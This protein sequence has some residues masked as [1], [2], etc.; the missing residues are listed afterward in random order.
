MVENSQRC[1]DTGSLASFDQARAW[2][3]TCITEHEHCRS[4]NSTFC[5]TRLLRLDEGAESL[6]L[7]VGSDISPG[8]QYATLS[9]CW[10]GTVPGQLTMKNIK[11]LQSSVPQ[12]FLGKTFRDAAKIA[13]ELGLRFIWIDS[14]CIIQDSPEDWQRESVKISL[15]YGNSTCNIA[16]T[17]ASNSS[18]GCFRAHDRSTLKPVKFTFG[19]DGRRGTEDSLSL[20]ITDVGHWWQRFQK[21]PLNR[22]AWVVQ[23]RLL[24]TRNIHYERDQ[25]VWECNELLASEIY[26]KGFGD[27]IHQRSRPLRVP[28]DSALRNAQ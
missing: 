22:R 27:L 7:C 11:A 3:K 8:T 10:G 28:L 1:I 5:P 16:A 6:R 4:I 24:S 19:R 17:S 25:L 13:L 12:E 26:P 15:I 9:H 20:Y 18:G 23:E 14:L 2:L 21:E